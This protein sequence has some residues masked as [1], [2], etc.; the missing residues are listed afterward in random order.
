[1]QSKRNENECLHSSMSYNRESSRWISK[2]I[3]FD[4]MKVLKITLVIL[5]L[6]CKKSITYSNYTVMKLLN[7]KCTQKSNCILVDECFFIRP[8]NMNNAVWLFIS[9]L[10]V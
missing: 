9:S 5:F 1:M 10:P 4:N 7:W 2:M 6:S 8:V 3:M